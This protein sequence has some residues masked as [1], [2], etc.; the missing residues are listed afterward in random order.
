M[1]EIYKELAMSNAA[2]GTELEVSER[3]PKA[4]VSLALRQKKRVHHLS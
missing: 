4:V 1:V 3:V 2:R